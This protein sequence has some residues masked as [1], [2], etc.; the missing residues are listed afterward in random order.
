MKRSNLAPVSTA[1]LIEIAKMGCS[2]CRR[3]VAHTLL[4]MYAPPAH[5]QPETKTGTSDGRVESASP[6]CRFPFLAPSLCPRHSPASFIGGRAGGGGRRNIR[7]AR[8]TPFGKD[9]SSGP[10]RLV[11]TPV[12]GHVLPFREKVVIFYARRR[13]CPCP[14]SLWPP[15]CYISS[16]VVSCG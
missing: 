8:R 12:T 14:S 5:Q 10:R 15:S 2:A 16:G 6:A 13:I 7:H 3:G 1:T 4:C 11:R 9:P